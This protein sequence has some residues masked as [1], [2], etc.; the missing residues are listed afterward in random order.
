MHKA[1]TRAIHVS[2]DLNALE[3]QNKNCKAGVFYETVSLYAL[4]GVS[5]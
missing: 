3:F 1:D 2:L 4:Y 5:F